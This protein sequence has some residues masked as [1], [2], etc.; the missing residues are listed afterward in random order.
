MAKLYFYYSTMNAGKS[1]LLLQSS[2]NYREKGLQTL[3][4]IP[5][6]D[7]RY[8]KGKIHSRIG[9]NEDAICFDPHFNF[10]T[11]IYHQIKS[12][13]KIACLLIDEAQFMTKKQIEE[14]T[15]IVDDLDIPVLTYG[16]RSDFRGEPFEGSLYL[17]LWADHL[18]EVKTICFCG[19][20]ATMN[21]Q[22]GPE[23]H[24][25]KSGNQIQIGGNEKYISFC[26]KHFKEKFN[27]LT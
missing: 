7:S 22:I 17:L 11:Y 5:E 2:Y 14:L 24:A 18:I 27:A 1:T 26:R 19:R 3:L 10:L 16:L 12:G 21:C 4:F 6:V 25:I 15:H 8:Q 9:L 13:S 20:K 23:G